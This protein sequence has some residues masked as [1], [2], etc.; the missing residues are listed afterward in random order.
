VTA[1]RLQEAAAAWLDRHKDKRFFLFL[2]YWDV[3]YDYDSGPPYDTMFDPDYTGTV[4]GRNFYFDPTINREM[5]KRDLE[6]VIALY[7]GEIRLVDDH[8]A[9]LR[10]KLEALGIDGRTVILVTAD[11]GDEFFEHG[12]KGHHRTLY[13]EILRVPMV[14]YV[15]GVEPVRPV[16]QTEASIIDVVPTLLGVTGIGVPR[17]VEGWDLSG[18]A[19]GGEAEIERRTI[20]ELYR[21]NSLNVQ[22]S[23]RGEDQ[24]VIHHFNRRLAEVYDVGRE[25]T[26]H[27]RLPLHS[28]FAPLRIADLAGWLNTE[29]PIF[30]SRVREHGIE[31]IHMDDATR[32]R[33][34]SLGY[35]Q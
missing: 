9:L 23:I 35:L 30:V 32:D 26:E 13:D 17:G 8:L 7:D 10:R 28:G 24:K 31:E 3:H 18:I 15:P 33:L 20:G 1:P 5:P 4:T 19:F 34:R 29:W 14:L 2:H 12:R 27:E 16:V 11:H 22:V 6:H 25:P 21:K